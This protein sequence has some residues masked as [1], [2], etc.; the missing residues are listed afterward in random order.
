MSGETYARRYPGGF[1]DLPLQTT[2][3]D[4]LFLNEVE[5]ALLIL[6]GADPTDKAVQVWDAALGRFKTVL[7]KNENFDPAAGISRTK[8]DFGA[9]LVNADIAP[10]AAL[11]Y[12]K[13]NLGGSIVNG[14]I[15]AAAAIVASKLAGYPSDVTKALRGDGSWGAVL[16]VTGVQ[17]LAGSGTY[18]PT[19]GTNKVLVQA[20]GGGGGG[21]GAGTTGGAG[22]A[23]GGGGGGG[24]YSEK[25]LTS[26]FSGVAYVVGA[27][28]NG[29]ATGINAGVAGGDTT[30]G[31][32]LVVAKGGGAGGGGTTNVP[33]LSALGGAAASGTGDVKLDGGRGTPYGRGDM[34]QFSGNG[35]DAARGG[36]GGRISAI[37]STSIV[38]G[39]NGSPYGGGGSGGHSANIALTAAGG[40]GANGMIVVYEF[41]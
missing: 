4:S 19:P 30:F 25:L 14:D 22:G 2:A 41:A 27:G 16:T 8:L 9:G 38:N 18:T 7:L 28:G 5:A 15:A 23:S 1:V 11:A 33:L 26:G 13:L 6:L 37:A 24:A 20:I 40:N 10:G 17:V 36:F 31:T 21:G 3:I 39:T 29:G 12:S 34:I 32:T 35:G